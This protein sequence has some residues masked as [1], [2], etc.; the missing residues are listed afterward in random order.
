MQ[1]IQLRSCKASHAQILQQE[2][3]RAGAQ[4]HLERGS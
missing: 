4:V 3:L 2:E 1:L